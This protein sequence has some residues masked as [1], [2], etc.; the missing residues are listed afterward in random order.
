MKKEE[1]VYRDLHIN[2]ST[3]AMADVLYAGV[4][5]SSAFT[6]L[7]TLSG[8]DYER[9]QNSR[10]GCSIKVHIHPDMIDKFESLSGFKLEKPQSITI[11]TPTR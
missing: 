3:K 7:W 4:I 2:M 1:Y 11:S 5:T 9:K 8:R 10:N 6:T